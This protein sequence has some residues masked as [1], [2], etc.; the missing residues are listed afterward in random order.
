MEP[1]LLLNWR[2][3]ILS[4]GLISYLVDET[5]PEL[6]WDACDNGWYKYE[7][8]TTLQPLKNKRKADASHFDILRI[9]TIYLRVKW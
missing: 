4:T 8:Y 3:P 5:W 7:S 2:D 1:F 9:N 6:D